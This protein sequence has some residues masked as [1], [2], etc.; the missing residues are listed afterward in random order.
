VPI[1]FAIALRFLFRSAKTRQIGVFT[2][3]SVLGIAAS[4]FVFLLIDTIINGL[5]SHLQ[6]S[7]I[8]FEAPL[9]VPTD[10]EGVRPTDQALARF[11]KEH[12]EFNLTYYCNKQFDGLIQRPAQSAMGVKVKTAG[13]EFFDIKQE[14]VSVYWF[15]G[16]SQQGFVG[17]DNQVLLG[18]SLYES[19]QFIPGDDEVV[20]ITHPFADI[21]PTGEMEPS[22]RDF[23]LAGIFSTGRLAFD[24]SFALV[25]PSGLAQLSDD[26][27]LEKEYYIFPRQWE[28]LAQIQTLWQQ[29]RGAQLGVMKTWFDR[30]SNLFKA[31]KLEQLMYFV[32]FIFVFLIS[33]FNMAALISIFGTSKSKETAILS[34]LGLRLKQARLIFI[35]IGFVLGALGTLVGVGSALLLTVIAQKSGFRLP[36]AYG[37]TELPLA[38]NVITLTGLLLGTPLFTALIACV[39]AYRLIHRDI[40]QVMR[41]N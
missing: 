1:T 24:E 17:S 34:A 28:S 19:L 14:Q 37:F 32:I 4:V 10:T 29:G 31:M 21:G 26:D 20:S 40:T 13:Q 18:E 33:C 36:E 41:E 35:Q 7:L 30:N 39:P 6:A 12:S 16:F 2:V 25:S 23:V 5:T 22:Q 15:D 3:V 38:I 8:G 11:S 9:F 27:F